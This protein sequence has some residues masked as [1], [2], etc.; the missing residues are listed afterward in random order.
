RPA[1][2]SF[3]SFAWKLA[4]RAPCWSPPSDR[5]RCRRVREQMSVYETSSILRP[6]CL[7]AAQLA[8]ATRRMKQADASRKTRTGGL[9]F[10]RIVLSLAVAGK[11]KPHPISRSISS[12][13]RYSQARRLTV[14]VSTDEARA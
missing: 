8:R 10:P 3:G 13:V 7:A 14:T 9:Q 5:E 2:L 1:E 12:S 4:S 6:L 11:L